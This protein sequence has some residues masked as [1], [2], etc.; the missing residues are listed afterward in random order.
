VECL[1]V[2][3]YVPFFLEWGATLPSITAPGF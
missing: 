2:K 3:R 1:N